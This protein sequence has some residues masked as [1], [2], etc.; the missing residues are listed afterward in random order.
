MK[1]ILIVDDHPIVHTGLAN[2][3]ENVLGKCII[4]NSYTY[5]EA[6]N[7]VKNNYIDLI[8]LD[9]NIPGSLGIEVISSFRKIQP[10]LK[11]LVC[12]GRDELLHAQHMIRRGAN[13]FL[14]K[15][16]FETEAEKAVKMVFDNKIYLSQKVQAQ[17]LDG[18]INNQKPIVDPMSILTHR[19]KE[20]LTLLLDGMWIKEIAENLQIK[21]STVGTMK[22]R[23]FEKLKVNSVLELYKI[24]E[25]YTNELKSE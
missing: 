4:Y 12:S 8:L 9:L 7:I 20:I 23:I 2:L 18:L 24:I 22:A 3:V 11:I 5:Q 10:G 21:Y 14:H 17:F 19:E 16:T 25:L 6:S 1:K 15:N 13:G